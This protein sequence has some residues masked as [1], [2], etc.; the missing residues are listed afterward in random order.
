MPEMS[1]AVSHSPC[2]ASSTTAAKPSRAIVSA[3][4]G[5]P[6]MHQPAKTVSPERRRRARAKVDSLI[7]S[8]STRHS[9]GEQGE[10]TRNPKTS[11]VPDSGSGA[12][13]PRLGR[14]RWRSPRM[15]AS[16]TALLDLGDCRRQQFGHFRADLLFGDALGLQIRGQLARDVV[17]A[18]F[19]EVGHHDLLGIGLRV[20][21]AFAE[22]SGGPQ[23]EHLVAAGYR[24]EP[25]LFVVR[26]LLLEA[27]FALVESC[28]HA[29]PRYCDR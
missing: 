18:H 10:R 7:G 11:S 1:A 3:T 21:A 12:V 22:N 5:E 27:L 15:T 20:R 29:A 8:H 4:I 24:L 6:S 28:C 14:T 9:G 17:I 16:L 23:P 2:W 19:L 25:E 26:E 13:G